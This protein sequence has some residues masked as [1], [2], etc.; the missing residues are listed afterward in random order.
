MFEIFPPERV[1]ACED[2]TLREEVFA[3]AGVG[4]V[5]VALDDV[6]ECPIV[7]PIS[8]C[9]LNDEIFIMEGKIRDGSANREDLFDPFIFQGGVVGLGVEDAV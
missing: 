3:E 9:Q 1:A 6:D 2:L 4:I 7:E 8:P 5:S